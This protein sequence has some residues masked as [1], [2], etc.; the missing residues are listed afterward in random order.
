MKLLISKGT[1]ISMNLLII[2]PYA[3]GLSP[4]LYLSITL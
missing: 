2:N 4:L 1:C 3:L